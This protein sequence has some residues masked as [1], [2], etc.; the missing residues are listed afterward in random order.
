MRV[1]AGWHDSTATRMSHMLW[2]GDLNMLCV[3]K[4]DATYRFGDRSGAI[5]I[6]VGGN[7]NGLEGTWNGYGL[8]AFIQALI[9]VTT[10]VFHKRHRKPTIY[11]LMNNHR[12]RTKQVKGWQQH[13]HWPAAHLVEWRAVEVLQLLW[14]DERWGDQGWPVVGWTRV[15]T[16]TLTHHTH[17]ISRIRDSDMYLFVFENVIVDPK[18]SLYIICCLLWGHV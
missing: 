12:Y 8:T 11:T 5:G 10:C 16:P 7:W 9:F 2:N 1:I 4:F 15:P 17:F 14:G 6:N 18:W 3:F 13:C